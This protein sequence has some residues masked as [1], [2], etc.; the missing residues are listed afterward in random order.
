MRKVTKKNI[1][2]DKD[3]IKTLDVSHLAEQSLNPNDWLIKLVRVN[4]DCILGYPHSLMT[5]L[6]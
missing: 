3:A 4:T 1:K 5:L 6:S 2:L